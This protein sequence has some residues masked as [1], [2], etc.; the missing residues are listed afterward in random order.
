MVTT[1]V[2]RF[3][4]NRRGLTRA[5]VTAVGLP[6]GIGSI[7]GAGLGTQLAWLVNPSLLKV[8]LGCLLLAAAWISAAP[9]A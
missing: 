7:V 4:V 3:Y 2:G 9:I 6:M 8:A 1:S 5:L